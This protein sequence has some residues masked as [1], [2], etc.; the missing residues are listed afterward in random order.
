[1]RPLRTLLTGAIDYAGLFP[2]ASLDLAPAAANYAAYRTGD[3][4][5][6]LGRLVVP[7]S[8]LAEFGRVA[9]PGL[10]R[11]GSPWRLTALAA[12]DLAA[13]L[14][15]V[16]AFNDEQAG[17]AVVD[18][19]E[20]KAAA[21]A[22]E[23]EPAR[24][25]FLDAALPALNAGLETYVELPVRDDPAPLMARLAPAGARA[26]IRTGGVT[27]DAFPPPDQVARFIRRAVEAGVPFKATAGLHHPLHGSYR[28]TYAPDSDSAPMYGFLNLFLAAA[29]VSRGLD[30]AGAR[31]LLRESS[32]RAFRFDDAGI[33][34]RDHR[35]TDADLRRIRREVVVAFG[36]CS[37]REPLDEL[38]ALGLP[39]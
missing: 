18:A 19:V 3:D 31:A 32:P 33:A 16:H 7:A 36:S 6:A 17:R 38:R 4:R 28:L 22:A 1:M 15:A 5:W 9:A 10:E 12:A 25:G 23:L 35:V 34:W 14:A 11:T 8:R 37:F 27:A 26:K 2:P 20:L 21:S 29:L 30:E 13:D 39:L 24:P